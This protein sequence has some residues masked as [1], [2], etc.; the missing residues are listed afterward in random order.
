MRRRPC[1]KLHGRAVAVVRT[2]AVI[3]PIDRYSSKLV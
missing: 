1:G 3:D 2:A